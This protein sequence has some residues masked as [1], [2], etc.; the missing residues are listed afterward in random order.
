[1]PKLPTLSTPYSKDLQ[2]LADEAAF[3]GGQGSRNLDDA[4]EVSEALVAAIPGPPGQIVAT[5]SDPRL[6]PVLM[7]AALALSSACLPNVRGLYANRW[8]AATLFYGLIAPPGANKGLMGRALRAARVLDRRLRDESEAALEALRAQGAAPEG[9]DP[10]GLIL[11]ADAS[12]AGLVQ[13]LAQAGHPVFVVETEI[14]ATVGGKSDDWRQTSPFLRRAGEHEPINVLRKGY[15]IYVDRPEVAVLLAGTPDQLV[16]LI[17]SDQDGLYSR[18]LWLYGVPVEEWISPRPGPGSGDVDR[19]LEAAGAELDRLHAALSAREQPLEFQL[20]PRHWNLFDA[21]YSSIK[22][23]VRNAGYGAYVDSIVHRSGVSAFRLAML[24]SVLD[25]LDE[26]VAHN[27]DT[28]TASDAHVE[29]GLAIALVSLDHG[30]RL[31]GLLPSHRMTGGDTNADVHDFFLE[32]PD[33]EFSRATG[34]EVGKALGMGMRTADKHLSTLAKSGRLQK[35]RHGEYHK[36]SAGPQGSARTKHFR[37]G[38]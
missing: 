8:Y 29:L 18:F 13:A 30:L 22:T 34:I 28:L 19:V 26:V 15:A 23:K 4:V 20:E 38:I 36:T 11:P 7:A 24:L 32:L 31:H 14:D 9:T 33:G 37:R 21:L 2:H 10:V 3:S 35:V 25:R 16:R 6:H 27:P 5:S 1:M 17:P 12:A